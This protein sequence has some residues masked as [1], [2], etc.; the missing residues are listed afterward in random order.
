MIRQILQMVMF[1]VLLASLVMAAYALKHSS[2]AFGYASVGL[3][4]SLI[5]MGFMHDVLRH[6]ERIEAALSDKGESSE[7][8]TVRHC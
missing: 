4:L 7:P 1:L 5:P 6:L 8:E 2:I 3:F